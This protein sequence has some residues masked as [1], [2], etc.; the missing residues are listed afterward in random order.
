MARNI[1]FIALGIIKAIYIVGTFMH[2]KHEKLS[3]ATMIIL[4]MIFI[5][6]FLFIASLILANIVKTS[7]FLNA[8]SEIFLL[9]SEYKEAFNSKPNNKMMAFS[10]TN[11]INIKS[12]PIEPY[13]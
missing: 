5:I 12:V 1:I 4:P 10:Q 2:M 8:F 3:L 6:F 13:N 11:N 7:Y 9:F